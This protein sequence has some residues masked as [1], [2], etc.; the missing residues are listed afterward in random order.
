MEMARS[1]GRGCRL[2]QE[3]KQQNPPARGDQVN[4]NSVS[5]QKI[6]ELVSVHFSRVFF[7]VSEAICVQCTL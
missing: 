2:R 3:A 7:F 1:S 4:K 5:P 6:T